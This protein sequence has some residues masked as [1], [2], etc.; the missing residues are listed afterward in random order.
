MSQTV[1][2]EA[3]LVSGFCCQGVPS[4]KRLALIL[5]R[6]IWAVGMTLDGPPDIS[7]YPNADGKGGEGC[8]V[9]QKLVESWIVGGTWPAHG[10][11]RIVLSSCKPYDT[12]LVKRLLESH[13]GPITKMFDND[14]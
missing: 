5:E 6:I 1:L 4:P 13:I 8:Q 9:Y 14:L 11:T 2:G 10:F 12:G 7:N 3:E